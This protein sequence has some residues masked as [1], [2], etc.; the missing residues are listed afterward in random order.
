MNANRR[1]V[2]RCLGFAARSGRMASRKGSAMVAPISAEE[3]SGGGGCTIG[4]DTFM[5]CY[6]VGNG[7]EGVRLRRFQ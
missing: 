3:A 1:G 5:V 6:L 4:Q 2:G 7:S